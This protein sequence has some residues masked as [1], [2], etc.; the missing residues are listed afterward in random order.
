[1][2]KRIKE[3][4]PEFFRFQ[5]FYNMEGTK[6]DRCTICQKTISSGIHDLVL[7]I[8]YCHDHA[9][10]DG[11]KFGNICVDPLRHTPGGGKFHASC[12]LF[13]DG[14][15]V[16]ELHEFARLIGLRRSWFQDDAKYP[17]YDLTAYKREQAIKNG[18]KQVGRRYIIQ[19]AQTGGA[20]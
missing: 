6:S 3:L 9:N 7:D 10:E 20:Q 4:P 2:R 12:H 17:H 13:T 15:D 5:T 1:M 19:V 18:A 14:G 8:L 16:G 11:R